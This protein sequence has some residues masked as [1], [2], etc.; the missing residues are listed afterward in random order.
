MAGKIVLV[1]GC[2]SGIGLSAAILLASDQHKRFKV[3]ATMRNL[4][5][6]KELEERGKYVLGDTLFIK[7]MD[8]CSDDSVNAVVQEVI[9]AHQRIDVVINNAGIGYFGPLE[10]QSMDSARNIFETNF[11]G[12][13]RLTR[14]VLP[15]MKS[16]K[17]GHIICVSSMGGI[18]GVP[19][20][21]IYCASK[22]AVE[23]LCESL[24]PLLKTF[25]VRCSVIEPGPVSTS[26]F[27]NTKMISESDALL[28]EVDDETK[29]LLD[30]C[31]KK[32]RGSFSTMVQTPDEIAQVILEALD[33]ERPHFR[34][35]TNK[36]YVS[37]AANKLVDIT[38][39]KSMEMMHQRFFS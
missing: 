13:L 25:N 36:N 30:N 28:D 7:A 11:F 4:E 26:F 39:D 32:M 18:N 27:A 14:A 35:Q 17:E 22:F 6:K 38:G 3:Y 23:G 21:G 1:S 2:S 31:V 16:N 29:H 8:V 24:A 20:N 33:A 15:Y 12:V 9:S 37:A 10:V 34:Y 19:F 5:K